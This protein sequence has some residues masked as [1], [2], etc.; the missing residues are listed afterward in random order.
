MGVTRCV[1]PQGCWEPSS[2]SPLAPRWLRP[3][4]HPNVVAFPQSLLLCSANCCSA[5]CW[6]PPALVEV[7]PCS[8]LSQSL[9]STVGKSLDS[10]A[11]IYKP[12]QLPPE[13]SS[14][15]ERSFVCRFRCLLDNSSGFLVSTDPPQQDRGRLTTEV[16]TTSETT[17]WKDP[18][19]LSV[20]CST[21]LSQQETFPIFHRFG[22]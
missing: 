10:S 13:N 19:L 12:D 1:A 7:N 20:M 22:L 11:V 6:G 9:S 18:M 17:P 8:I 15:L 4:L 16:H 3:W 21:C 5:Q 2:L 14:F